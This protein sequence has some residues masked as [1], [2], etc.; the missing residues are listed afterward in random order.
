MSR[1]EITCACIIPTCHLISLDRQDRG[2]APY[3]STWLKLGPCNCI[4]RE[5][6][7]SLQNMRDAP[8]MGIKFGTSSGISMD[9]EVT[10]V[11]LWSSSLALASHAVQIKEH[12]SPCIPITLQPTG[13][14]R[15]TPCVFYLHAYCAFETQILFSNRITPRKP[16]LECGEV[17]EG[18]VSCRDHAPCVPISIGCAGH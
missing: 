12:I 14:H 1:R 7:F 15:Q 17:S 4:D 5:S 8:N 6:L 11:A 2:V 18:E 3:V 9:H 10:T 16:T 13:T